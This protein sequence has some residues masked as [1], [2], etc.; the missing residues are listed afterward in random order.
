MYSNLFFSAILALDNF[1]ITCKV[2]ISQHF[3]ISR[4][5]DKRAIVKNKTPKYILYEVNSAS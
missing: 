3:P 1:C 2:Y 5:I 4:F